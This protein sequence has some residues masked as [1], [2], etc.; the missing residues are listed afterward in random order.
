MSSW[1]S[2]PAVAQRSVSESDVLQSLDASHPAIRALEGLTSEARGEHAQASKWDNPAIWLERESFSRAVDEVKYGLSWTLPVDGRRS[3]RGRAA[4]FGLHAAESDV[5]HAALQIRQNVREDYAAWYSAAQRRESYNEIY[6]LAKQLSLM[7]AERAASGEASRLTSAR[8]AAVAEELRVQAK[9]AESELIRTAAAVAVWHQR[10]LTD[11]RPVR[12]ELPPPPARAD[13]RTRPDIIAA[14]DRVEQAQALRTLSN[15]WLEFPSIDVG[16]ID[17]SNDSDGLYLGLSMNVPLFN[18]NSA[19]R[20]RAQSQWNAA[21]AAL[22]RDTLQARIEW[23]SALLAYQNLRDAVL[24]QTDV[25]S[26]SEQIITAARASFEA[27]ELAITDLLEM[28]RSAQS[29]RESA[30]ELHNSA[31]AAH[32]RLELAAGQPLLTN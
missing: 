8:L 29:S 18:R 28:L 23:E 15:R 6:E 26:E 32:R 22:E 20:A 2:R 11:A 21:R 17:P 13:I 4:R 12:P 19:E 9:L 1:V 14:S 16:R 10:P 31:L 25:E 5:D 3:A 27:G 24:A 7:M 30:L